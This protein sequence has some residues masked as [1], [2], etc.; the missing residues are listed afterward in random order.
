LRVLGQGDADASDLMTDILA[1]VATKTESNKN[2]GNAVLYECVETIMAIED[3][4]SLRVLAINILGRFLSNRDNNIRYVALNMLMKAITFDDQA[5]QRHRVTILEC[6]K[7]PDAS[8]RKRALELV[9]L[10][11][12]ENNVTQLTKE[13]IDYLEISDE[14]FKEDLSA[15]ICFIV[16]KFSPEKLWYIDQ[17]LKVLCEAGK[18]VKDDVWHAL[19]VVISNA[20]ELHGY[21]VRALYKSVL[22]YSEQ[23]TLVRVAVWCIGE[24]GDL[25]VNNVGMLGIEDP[26][27]VSITM[28]ILIHYLLHDKYADAF[29]SWDFI[30]ALKNMQRVCDCL[31][32]VT[33]SDAVDVIEDAI[34]RHN[35]DST[36][37]AMALVA[38][39]KLS[40]R[41]PSIS[42]YV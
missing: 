19:I 34:T 28:A 39:L 10:L 41:F 23:E 3:T 31:E 8:I 7:D 12:N 40:S 14:D 38:L 18:F 1:Q 5:V 17:M 16:E 36:T 30:F 24:Y 2:A 6:V 33:E 22:T 35:S 29:A 15:K 11:V 37:K 13:L 27:T 20:S 21:T 25:L 42:E 4:N 32:Q 9:T 26:I